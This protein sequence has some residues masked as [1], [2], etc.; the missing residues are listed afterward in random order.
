MS[1]LD[2]FEAN[3]V[4]AMPVLRRFAISVS[5]NVSHA[6]DLVQ[7]TVLKALANRTQFQPG[8]NLIAWLTVILR[9]QHSTELRKKRREIQDADGLIAG[10]VA[11][12]DSPLRK[13][14]ALEVLA[15]IDKMPPSWRK[16]LR[17]IADGASYE[18]IA[19]EQI[20]HIGT[21]KSRAHRGREFLRVAT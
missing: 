13:M 12:E 10:K 5:R 18:E 4:A 20:E 19:L 6:D 2:A 11:I 1:R 16:V 15:M 7:E 21:I 8:T 17:S 3:V 9:N 14:E